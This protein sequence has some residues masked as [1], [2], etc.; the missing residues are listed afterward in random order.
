MVR[1]SGPSDAKILAIFEAPGKDEARIGVP[2]VGLS[3]QKQSTCWANLGMRRQDIRI[4]NVLEV[5]PP[6]NDL[7]AMPIPQLEKAYRS[8][9][10]RIAAMDP[11]PNVIVPA[12][13]FA[14]NALRR[15]PI[16]KKKEKGKLVLD[17]PDRIMSWRGSICEYIDDNGRQRKMIPTIHPRALLSAPTWQ[18]R[19]EADWLRIKGDSEFPELRRFSD[20]CEHKI[21]P[22]IEELYK[23]HA[24][25][26]KRSKDR[27][28]IVAIDIETPNRVISCIGFSLDPHYSMTVGLLPSH[29]KNKADLPRA[30][31]VVRSI[32][33]L[34]IAKATHGGLFDAYYMAMVPHPPIY[35]YEWLW[36]TQAEHHCM[37][38]SDS[39][40]LAYCASRDIRVEFWKDEAKEI[41]NGEYKGR[42]R[43][44]T[45]ELHTYNGKDAC[46]TR[47]LTSVYID[48]L[49]EMG[50][51]RF[52]K[53]H[54]RRKFYPV[55]NMM[56][57]G[58]PID[59]QKREV[60]FE[61]ERLKLDI[62][63]RELKEL[64]GEDL[65]AKKGLSPTRVIKYFYGTLGCKPPRAAKGRKGKLSAGEAQVRWL[66][67][68]TKKAV[69]G[70]QKVLDFRRHQKLLNSFS[71]AR[72]DDDGRF[73]STYKFLTR[74]SRFSSSKNPM[75]GGGNAQN[76]DR[77][78]RDM[79]VPIR[80]HVLI[81]LDA[82][83]G[84][85]R[86]RDAMA[87][88][89]S[90][91]E[92]MLRLATASPLDL[93]QHREH[94]A[95]ILSILRGTEVDPQDVTGTERQ[96]GK[97]TNHA[98][99]YGMGGVMMAD[100]VLTDSKGQLVLTPEECQEFIDALLQRLP[101][102]VRW[103]EEIRYLVQHDRKLETSWGRIF[104]FTH[105][106]L[107]DKT[108]KDAYSAIPQCD[109][110]ELLNQEGFLPLAERIE[111]EEMGSRILAQEHDS[112]VIST[113]LEEAWGVVDFTASNLM[114]PRKYWGTEVSMPIGV[115]LGLDWGPGM[116]EWKV[117]PTR[118]EFV[119]ALESM[120]VR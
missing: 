9:H 73:R 83:Q 55:L 62:L 2:L 103:Q 101:A 23:F 26:A 116:R 102:I 108:Y 65:V 4:E 44:D 33:E 25:L 106:R 15:N 113:P 57:E 69:P 46:Y 81:E 43:R 93:D 49:R 10:K 16:R 42:Y 52:Y 76:I 34:P 45:A 119:E 96:I 50:L 3:G 92:Y 11:P 13:N 51:L 90:N 114:K 41:E 60:A 35:F 109:L 64:T 29:W 20:Q 12:G 75:G 99:G 118:D 97:R 18:G 82:A 79:F 80:G 91:D 86:I 56:L 58:M 98:I 85:S 8:I 54:Y 67:V 59:E 63:R 39:H 61:R 94:A 77:E 95:S 107:E 88:S 37:D 31:N 78:V 38:S 117:V 115:K 105:D 112:L 5:R 30:W 6:G 48:R 24:M 21:F 28:E 53:E 100:Q 68:K 104:R 110:V 66:M 14:L 84:E 19:W 89:V 74:W 27:G 120:E 32:C 70:G 22:T 87:Y 47:A 36:D 40:S 71:E 17:Y 1:G 111:D 72:V 7:D